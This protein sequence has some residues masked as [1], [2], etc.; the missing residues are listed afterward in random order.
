MKKIT[1]LAAALCMATAF[2]G[3]CAGCASQVE[4]TVEPDNA[5]VVTSD[6]AANKLILCPGWNYSGKTKKLNTLTASAD[7]VKLTAAEEGNLSL[8]KNGAYWVE[9][10]YFCNL[11]AGATLPTPTKGRSDIEFK[12]WRM[13]IDGVPTIVSTVPA[14]TET[15]VLYAHWEATGNGGPGPTPDP[16][17][18]PPQPQPGGITVTDGTASVTFN[19]T[20]NLSGITAS[21]AH[22]HMWTTNSGNATGE[23][24]GMSV[25]S[26]TVSVTQ[27]V[28]AITGIIVNDGG[29]TQTANITCT[30][31]FLVNGGVYTINCSAHTITKTN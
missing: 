31:G 12:G 16:T 1:S 18:D 25:S 7:I 10:A 21:N 22:L 15:T 23:W 11:A 30:A 5:T 8:E 6:V 3:F 9:N 2:C 27:P 28:G 13:A 17:P 20:Y 4:G 19:I 29:S 24:P 14:I 26:G